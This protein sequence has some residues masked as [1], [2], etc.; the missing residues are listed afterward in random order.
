MND[1]AEINVPPLRHEAN[2]EE[3]EH[4]VEADYLAVRSHA[5]IAQPNDDVVPSGEN[6]VQV[7]KGES[8]QISGAGEKGSIQ[9]GSSY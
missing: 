5:A 3:H 1:T 7:D 4:G 9:V 2:A 8:M 6:T